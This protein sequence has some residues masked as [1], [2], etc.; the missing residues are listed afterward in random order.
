VKVLFDERHG[1]L[2]LEC[3]KVA[4]GIRFIIYNNAVICFVQE[5]QI[6]EEDIKQGNVTYH[7]QERMIGKSTRSSQIIVALPSLI[8]RSYVQDFEASYGCRGQLY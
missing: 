6:P 7:K 3:H 4:I 2:T 5:S 8:I 1:I